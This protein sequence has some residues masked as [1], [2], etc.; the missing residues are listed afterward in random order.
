M[1]FVFWNAGD[2]TKEKAPE[3][4]NILVNRDID[5]FCIV[6]ADSSSATEN[7]KKRATPGYNIYTL[8]C[9]RRKASGMI[10]GVKQQQL[11]SKS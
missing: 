10:V 9:S 2:Y 1:K 3:F 6:E 8:P 11:S 7:E 5:A 4:Q